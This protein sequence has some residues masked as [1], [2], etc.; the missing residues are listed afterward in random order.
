MLISFFSDT[1]TSIKFYGYVFEH[2]S[3]FNLLTFFWFGLG[4]R[5]ENMKKGFDMPFM[6]DEG[7]AIPSKVKPKITK[8]PLEP[9]PPRIIVNL[10]LDGVLADTDAA[11][12]DREKFDAQ[13]NG[14]EWWNNLYAQPDGLKK[15]RQSVFREPMFYAFIPKM[16]HYADLVWKYAKQISDDVQILSRLEVPGVDEFTLNVIKSARRNWV[17][18]NFDARMKDCDINLV[19]VPKVYFM[20]PGHVNILVDD[21]VENIAAWAKN[22]GIGIHYDIVNPEIA[23]SQL[24]VMADDVRD[25]SFDIKHN[26]M[27]PIQVNSALMSCFE[28]EKVHS[29]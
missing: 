8:K 20:K 12:E 25:L 14:K 3:R 16:C 21:K 4:L 5:Y 2:L 28:A 1:R 29:R 11:L 26:I 23:I 17:R 27:P 18:D 10:D 9:L 6:F 22:G 19:S 13:V 7:F 15:Y 24:R